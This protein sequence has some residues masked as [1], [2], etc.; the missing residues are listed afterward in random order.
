[1]ALDRLVQNQPVT[2]LTSSPWPLVVTN[3]FSLLNVSCR[4]GVCGAF[5]KK[6][7]MTAPLVVVSF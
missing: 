5:L 6:N 1:M 7:T 3:L 2:H 4:V